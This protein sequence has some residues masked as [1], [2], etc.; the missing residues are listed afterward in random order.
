[1][2]TVHPICSSKMSDIFARKVMFLNDIKQVIL[3]FL[4]CRSH[5]FFIFKI[6][7][8]PMKFLL[9][10]DKYKGSL[11]GPDFCN[12]VAEGIAMAIPTATF[13]KKPLADGG[14]GTLAVMEQYLQAKSRSVT[15]HD[16]LLQPIKAK[17]LYDAKKRL[18]F[19]E[20]AEAS[21]HRLLPTDALNC[22][23]TTSLGTG[24][25]ILDAL[26]KGAREIVLG[27]GGSATTDGGLGIAAALGYEFLDKEGKSLSPIGRNM[28][29][30]EKVI[31]PQDRQKW[32]G[33]R[34]KLACDVTNPFYGKDGAAHVYGP[35]K[36]ASPEEVLQLDEGL[37]NLA[38][39][40]GQTFHIDVQNIKG[41]GAAGG[42]G[43]GMV[44]MF[45]A[46]I[47]PGIALIMELADFDK[48]LEKVD[49]V[50]TGEG[51]LDEQT[52]SG[53]TMAGVVSAAQ[54]RTIPVAALC[55][56]VSLTPQQQKEFGL[57]YATS[58]LQH[59]GTLQQAQNHAYA[60]LVSAAYNFAKLVG[61]K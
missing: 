10:P 16:P 19:I 51:L 33:V 31:M 12:A 26:Q 54:K 7:L 28:I 8:D 37:K 53:K 36:G 39:C 58:I 34:I 40:F 25:L 55:G 48:A 3:P 44:A 2:I 56:A 46:E 61:K 9:A 47:V 43:G 23:E 52:F 49:W 5:Q 17:Y 41:A 1:M 13:L 60:N 32:D 30:V 59:V 57:A 42:I 27:V 18:A 21:G 35:Q 6:N 15:V 29:K 20:M 38:Q 11:T 14:D 45:N 50:V 4:K 24:E 22:M